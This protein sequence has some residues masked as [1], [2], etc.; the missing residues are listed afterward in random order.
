MRVGPVSSS[1]RS[2]HGVEIKIEEASISGNSDNDLVDP[3]P[4]MQAD[5]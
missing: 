1:S 4:G 5:S 3:L 2:V